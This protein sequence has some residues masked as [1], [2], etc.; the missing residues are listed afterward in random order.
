MHGLFLRLR[1]IADLQKA[2]GYGTHK[3]CRYMIHG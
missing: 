1:C 3:G 2:W